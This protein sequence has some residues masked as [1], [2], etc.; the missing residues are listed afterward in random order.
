MKITYHPAVIVAFYLKC[1]PAD[2]EEKIPRSTK[3]DWRKKHEST[4]FG[5][6]WFCSNRELFETI[7]KIT[8]NKDLLKFNKALIKAI[9]LSR[10]IIKYKGALYAGLASIRKTVLNRIL[11]LAGQWKL[12]R[13]LKAINMP[14]SFFLKIKKSYKCRR[15][16]L[17]RCPVKHPGQLL[18]SEVAGI[19]KYC[20][21]EKYAA[22][23]LSSVYHKMKRDGAGFFALSTFY[24]YVV[25]LNIR[26]SKCFSRKK[27][28]S[29]GIRAE[30][31]LRLLHA[32]VTV[33]RTADNQKAYIY[34]I[35]DNFSRAILGWKVSAQCKVALA[36]ENLA[37][38][39]AKYL[40]PSG[41]SSC[42][43]LTD[44]GGENFG[45]ITEFVSQISAPSVQH[46]IAQVDVEFSNSMI[47]AANKQLKYHF[48]Y[49]KHIADLSNLKKYVKDAVEDYN[50]R[51]HHV[52]NG[53]TPLEVLNGQ[54]P[55]HKLYKNE[56]IH[57]R[58]KRVVENKKISCCHF[59]F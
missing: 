27:N 37:G 18:V 36:F 40:Q 28:H 56:M 2:I 3:F 17:D 58:M 54:S 33:L 10:F 32:D 52:L 47:E 21:D 16:P 12:S 39:Y 59:S 34:L 6:E 1:L 22:W 51:P 57:S 23:P 20:L 5:Y 43:L 19:E 35:Q 42:D 8:L 4:L 15:S 41:I 55:D 24:K 26:R 46:L 44:N 9:A 38:V 14:Y 30:A 49:H 48:L 29:T 25:A 50:N 53:L 11:E 13:V 45:P 7:E 31:P